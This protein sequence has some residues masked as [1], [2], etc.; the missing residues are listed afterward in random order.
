MFTHGKHLNT[1]ADGP[2][3]VKVWVNTYRMYRI[4]HGVVWGHA[5]M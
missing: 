5:S 2:R 3:K 1:E 4:A